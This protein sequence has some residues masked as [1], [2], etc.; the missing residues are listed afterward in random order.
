MFEQSPTARIRT[1]GDGL[2]A[3]P[4]ILG[5]YE[6]FMAQLAQPEVLRALETVNKENRLD[7]PQYAELRNISHQ[8]SRALHDW[9]KENMQQLIPF[10]THWFSDGDILPAPR[11]D[12]RQRAEFV[13]WA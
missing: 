11:T 12:L 6:S 8:F 9:L 7:N 1:I 13:G 10:T 3:S 4:L 5:T 2:Q